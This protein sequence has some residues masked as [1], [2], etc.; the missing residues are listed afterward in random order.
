MDASSADR[1]RPGRAT[2]ARVALLL[3]LF[4]ACWGYDGQAQQ[5]GSPGTN[6]PSSAGADGQ[7]VLKNLAQYDSIFKSG[8]AATAVQRRME[9]IHVPGPF[10]RLKSRWRLTSEGGRVGYFMEM[11][12]RENPEY[13]PPDRRGWANDPMSGQAA[14]DEAMFVAMRISEYGYWGDEACGNHYQ[15]ASLKVMPDGQV[16]QVGTLHDTSLYPPAD[17][18]SLA[19]MRSFQWGLGRFFSANIEKVERVEK[20]ADG[21]LLVTALGS[22]YQGDP[23]RWELEVEPAAA[24]MVRRAKFYRA[25][26]PTGVAAEMTNEGTTWS[27]SFCIPKEAQVNFFGPIQDTKSIRQTS[28]QQITFPTV[29]DNFDEVLYERC[30]REVLHNTQ[31]KLT[32][33]DERV[34]PPTITHPN[35]PPAPEIARKSNGPQRGWALIANLAVVVVLVGVALFWRGWKGPNPSNP[36]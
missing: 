16:T 18:S 30:R 4:A 32:V 26:E 29:V 10:Y 34:T 36:A 22:R 25:S 1:E 20:S 33:T 11:L 19:Q 9:P 23:G 17:V 31:P 7:D 5:A 6:T 35:A 14:R 24:W 15:D 3:P 12:E 8:F 13:L 27:G 2:G 21:H 28:T